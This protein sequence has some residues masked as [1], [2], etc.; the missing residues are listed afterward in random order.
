MAVKAMLYC[1]GETSPELGDHVEV[2]V[3]SLLYELEMAHVKCLGH[4]KILVEYDNK[5]IKPAIE[6][7]LPEI[8]EMVER[9][10]SAS[11]A[12]TDRCEKD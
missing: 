8:C 6:W 5:N 9:A 3:G 4:K 10:A 7:V 2:G 12:T 1:D 11:A